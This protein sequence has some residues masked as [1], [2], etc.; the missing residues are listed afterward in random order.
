MADNI[1][2]RKLYFNNGVFYIL[3]DNARIGV[4][5]ADIRRG[6]ITQYDKV[7]VFS[8]LKK[9][10]LYIKGKDLYFRSDNGCEIGF[11][12]ETLK[13]EMSRGYYWVSSYSIKNFVV[14]FENFDTIVP[15]YLS[16]FS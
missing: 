14:V 6:F 12:L 10:N 3:V 16:L 1:F 8:N 2:K 9:V 13:N 15:Q 7:Y 4:S 11:G 5:D